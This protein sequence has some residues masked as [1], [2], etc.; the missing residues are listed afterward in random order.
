M[1]APDIVAVLVGFA[2]STGIALAGWRARALTVDGALAAVVVGTLVYGFG[3]LDWAVVMVGFFV[4]SSGL[5][6]LGRQRKSA[7][8]VLSG[9]SSRRD[10]AQVLANGGVAALL[11]LA[12]I[13]PWSREA[14]LAGFVGAIAAVTSDTWS[15]EIGGLSSRPPRSILSGR[16]VPAGSSGG[17][18]LLGLLAAAAGGLFIGTL[19]A[20]VRWDISLLVIGLTAGFL[21]SIFDSICGAAIQ[22]RRY[23]DDCGE[24]TEEAVHHCGSRPRLLRG[25]GWVNNDVVN[26]LTSLYG[27]LIGLLVYLLLVR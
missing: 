7:V 2:A 23:C 5:S 1:T 26:A 8:A 16:V 15:T 6:Y 11:A 27:A 20:L 25:L 24:W 4:A 17:V 10:L 13:G 19:A 22:A 9:K 3:G 18:T 12:V 14:L 21:G